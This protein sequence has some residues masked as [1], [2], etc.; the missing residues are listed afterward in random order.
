VAR[1]LSGRVGGCEGR[2]V[3]G[4]TVVARPRQNL[5]LQN[6]VAAKQAIG[7]FSLPGGFVPRSGLILDFALNPEGT[8]SLISFVGEFAEGVASDSEAQSGLFNCGKLFPV[9]LTNRLQGD[10]QNFFLTTTHCHC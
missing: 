1:E 6:S 3:G 8:G 5:S 10:I 9:N 2:G 7:L 4:H